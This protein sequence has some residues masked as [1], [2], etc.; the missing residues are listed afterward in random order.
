MVGD[1]RGFGVVEGFCRCDFW[2]VLGE[3]YVGENEGD[4]KVNQTCDGNKI[5]W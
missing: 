4:E 1:A 3:F 5:L 2:G